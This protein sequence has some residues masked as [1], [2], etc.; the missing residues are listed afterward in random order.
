[1]LVSFHK[2]FEKK[3][4]KLPAKTQKQFYK[5]LELFLSNPFHKSLNNHPLHGEFE[6]SRSINITGDTRAIYMIINENN[7]LFMTIASHSE[8]YD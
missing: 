3:F 8:L 2:N 1:M 7:V 5:K 4:E 6:D